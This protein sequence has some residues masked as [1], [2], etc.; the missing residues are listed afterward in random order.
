MVLFPNVRAR[1]SKEQNTTDATPSI[2][3]HSELP[4]TEYTLCPRNHVSTT[5]ARKRLSGVHSIFATTK[6]ACFDAARLP[7]LPSAKH[8]NAL[9][10]DA[11]LTAS[12]S[13]SAKCAFAV[14][15]L[16]T[17][18]SDRRVVAMYMFCSVLYG[19]VGASEPMARFAPAS[20]S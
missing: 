14:A 10:Y 4:Y 12:L 8:E 20:R 5:L 19:A 6:F 18:R 13:D 1:S 2:A 3:P 7:V 17:S 15:V 9:P 16:S 11:L